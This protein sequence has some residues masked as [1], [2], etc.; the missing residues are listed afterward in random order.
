MSNPDPYF[1]YVS[2]E[3][4]LLEA[5][6]NAIKKCSELAVN[7]DPQVRL[8]WGS[9][10]TYLNKLIQERH[11]IPL[12]LLMSELQLGIKNA[13]SF[14]NRISAELA[15]AKAQESQETIRH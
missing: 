3:L 7:F 8:F 1:E 6:I 11:V 5:P 2:S 10:M 13:A 15:I 12:R 4:F 14:M 9:N